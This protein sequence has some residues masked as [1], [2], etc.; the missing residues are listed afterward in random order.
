MPRRTGESTTSAPN[1]RAGLISW[2]IK[3]G[4]RLGFHSEAGYASPVDGAVADVAWMMNTGQKPVF[5]FTLVEDLAG[6]MVFAMQWAGSSTEPKSWI[7]ICVIMRGSIEVPPLLPGGVKGYYV[8][9]L[10]SLR[11]SLEGFTDKMIRLLRNFTDDEPKGDRYE[12]VRRLSGITADWPRGMWNS[13]LSL[14]AHTTFGD[15]LKLFTAEGL[16]DEETDAPALKPSRKV[17]PIELVC[18][19]ASFEGALIRLV[20]AGCGRLLLSTEHRNYPFIFRLTVIEGGDS[21]L[22]LWFDTDKSNIPQALLFREL[23]ESVE[24]SG[25]VYF[26]SPSGV[27][28]ESTLKRGVS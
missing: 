14:K 5:T 7:H 4:A 9:N 10:D 25:S 23:V 1:D 3:E 11:H 26:S 18:D 28:A 22:D 24:A 20:K 19:D 6:L 27:L 12:T 21:D 13:R 8:E 17:V 16:E 2:L 15:G